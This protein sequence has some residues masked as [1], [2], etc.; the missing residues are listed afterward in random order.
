M[1]IF[2]DPGAQDVAAPGC[3][4]GADEP[5]AVSSLSAT[6]AAAAAPFFRRGVVTIDLAG[7][8][9]SVGRFGGQR[10][11]LTAPAESWGVFVELSAPEAVALGA[12]VAGW[13]GR[14]PAVAGF[15]GRDPAGAPS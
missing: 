10:R 15:A 4:A 5:A 2:R 13:A 8:A 9:F 12:A 7:R 3:A 6:G 1:S 11:L 14:E